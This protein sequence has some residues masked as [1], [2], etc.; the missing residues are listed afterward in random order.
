MEWTRSVLCLCLAGVIALSANSQESRDGVSLQPVKYAGLKDVVNR[1]RGKVILVDFWGSFC[2][3]C[4]QA[5]PHTL[6]LH[7]KYAK[8]GLALVSVSLDGIDNPAARDDALRFLKKVGADCTNLYLEEPVD[9]WQ[10]KLGFHSVPCYYVFSRQGQ[11]T[12]FPARD[13]EPL[14]YDAMENFIVERLREK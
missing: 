13:D 14:N 12:R 1:N 6:E 2:V 9:F 10:K 4:K 5:F 7:K 3:P 8:E 11:W